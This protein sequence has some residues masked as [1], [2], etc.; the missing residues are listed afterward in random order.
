MLCDA[1]E[2]LPDCTYIRFQTDRSVFTALLACMKTTDELITEPLFAA[3]TSSAASL[4]Q[5]R[6]PASPS[7]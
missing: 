6:T 7:A 2:D 1:K 5:P 4:M 3:N